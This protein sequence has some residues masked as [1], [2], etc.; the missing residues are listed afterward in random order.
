MYLECYFCHRWFAIHLHTKLPTILKE[1]CFLNQELL[2]RSYMCKPVQSTK[3]KP[4]YANLSFNISSSQGIM[5]VHHLKILFAGISFPFRVFIHW[6]IYSLVCAGIFC[7]T[8]PFQI[9]KHCILIQALWYKTVIPATF[10][11]EVG[12][13]DVHEFKTK[14]GKYSKGLSQ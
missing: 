11:G 1:K 10:E 9:I 12:R 6:I 8:L 13:A 2:I 7:S 5:N 14:M 4:P 3:Y